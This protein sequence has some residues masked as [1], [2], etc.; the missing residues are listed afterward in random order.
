MEIFFFFFQAED[1]IRD[2][3]VTGVQTCALP[4]SERD[5]I[6]PAGVQVLILDFQNREQRRDRSSAAQEH[7]YAVAR[8]RTQRRDPRADARH[9]AA[10]GRP[11]RES[12]RRSREPRARDGDRAGHRPAAS[13]VPVLHPAAA[14]GGVFLRGNRRYAG[15]APGYGENLYPSGP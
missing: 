3:K 8:W 4:I 10:I 15:A 13:G 1:G 11:Y 9:V 6:V 7:R 5:Q 2:Y 12:P 14:R